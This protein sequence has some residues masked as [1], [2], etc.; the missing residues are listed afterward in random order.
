M[1]SCPKVSQAS[2]STQKPNTMV[3]PF[4]KNNR[5]LTGSAIK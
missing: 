5:E 4:K 3:S 2:S 1:R